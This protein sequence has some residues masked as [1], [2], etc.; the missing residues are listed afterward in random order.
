MAQAR[1]CAWTSTGGLL[2]ACILAACKVCILLRAVWQCNEHACLAGERHRSGPYGNLYTNIHFGAA[3]RPFLSSGECRQHA[4]G[5]PL[6]CCRAVCERLCCV[7]AQPLVHCLGSP[8]T[9]HH[10][11]ALEVS[12]ACRSGLCLDAKAPR[13]AYAKCKGHASNCGSSPTQRPS[14]FVA[15]TCTPLSAMCVHGAHAAGAAHNGPHAGAYNTVWKA[16]AASNKAVPI[17][18]DGTTRWM[19]EPVGPLFNLV[20]LKGAKARSGTPPHGWWIDLFPKRGVAQDNLYLAMLQRRMGRSASISVQGVPLP[21]AVVDAPA[22]PSSLT[23]D[24]ANMENAGHRPFGG[25]SCT[26]SGKEDQSQCTY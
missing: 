6:S 24:D 4:V 16:W 22:V 18:Y 11:V 2:A 25:A 7:V 12:V 3:T 10:T 1:T 23:G 19:N 21:A 9:E 17:P 26:A 8:P 15:H 20:H 14:S 5:E 13:A